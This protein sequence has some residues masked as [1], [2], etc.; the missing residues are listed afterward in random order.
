MTLDPEQTS[1]VALIACGFRDVF[2]ARGGD[3]LGMLWR[4]KTV[5]VY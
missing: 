3:A 5:S 1:S 2:A 4:Q